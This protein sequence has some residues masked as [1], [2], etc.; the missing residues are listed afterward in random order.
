MWSSLFW[1]GF[2]NAW[3]QFIILVFVLEEV[4]HVPKRFRCDGINIKDK[5]L[6]PFFSC[7]YIKLISCQSTLYYTEILFPDF[8]KFVLYK[9]FREQFKQHRFV[10]RFDF[11]LRLV[12]V[13]VVIFIN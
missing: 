2:I 13:G 6:L 1:D 12:S 5:V 4:P 3:V 10:F 11:L 7:T 9:E 8:G